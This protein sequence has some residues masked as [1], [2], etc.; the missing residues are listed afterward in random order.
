MAMTSP[1][2]W[3]SAATVPVRF[4][5][6]LFGGLDGPQA[7]AVLARA[8]LSAD[9]LADDGFR[10]SPVLFGRL[11]RAAMRAGGDEMLGLHARPVPP[12]AYVRLL[13]FLVH[14]P[15]IATALDEAAGFY[16]LFDGAAPWT[17][18]ISGPVA[19]LRLAARGQAQG[20]SL[21]Y[22]HMMLLTVWQ[23]AGWL[24]RAEVPLR[25]VLLPAAFADYAAE[26]RFLFGRPPEFGEE[27]GLDWPRRVLAAPVTRRREEIAAFLRRAPGGMTAPGQPATLEAQLRLMLAASDPFATLRE[28][29]AAVQLGL[30]RQTLTRRLAGL[31]ISYQGIRDALRRDRA[32]ALLARGDQ[33]LGRIA[34]MLGY[35]E[36]SAF[37]RAFKQWTGL[38]P[39][40]YRRR[41]RPQG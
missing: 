26:A 32:C 11:L 41:H 10:A 31:G 6:D 25:R 19:R 7:C 29:E 20:Q 12:G 28:E 8:G 38:P 2:R 18:D 21:L 40:D 33:S 15:D 34:D 30:S 36:P 27:A 37:Q 1:P 13:H 16:R 39:G 23:T 4:L 17:I 3:A 35:S 24:G 5:R 9:A 14:C 22:A